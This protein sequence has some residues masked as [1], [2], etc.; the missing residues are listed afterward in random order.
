MHVSRDKYLAKIWPFVHRPSDPSG[1]DPTILLSFGEGPRSRY[2]CRISPSLAVSSYISC[3]RRV[4]S[5]LVLL[6]RAICYVLFQKKKIVPEKVVPELS[7]FVGRRFCIR[8]RSARGMRIAEY[9]PSRAQEVLSI[10]LLLFLPLVVYRSVYRLLVLNIKPLAG[11][12]CPGAQVPLKWVNCFVRTR[13][14]RIT[15]RVDQADRWWK[16]GV[17][18]AAPLSRFSEQLPPPFDRRL[19]IR[20][21]TSRFS[22]CRRF[23]AAWIMNTSSD[24]IIS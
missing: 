23:P 2:R 10:S 14:L 3:V 5:I 6:V 13:F 21:R 24:E 17:A 20:D 7:K 9:P 11:F 1:T 12:G 16:K 4:R 18:S 19:E 8:W 22:D 15:L